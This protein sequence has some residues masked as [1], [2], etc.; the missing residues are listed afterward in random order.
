MLIGM[1]AFLA[2]LWRRKRSQCFE[3]QIRIERVEHYPFE[4][5]DLIAQWSLANFKGHTRKA[6]VDRRQSATWNETFTVPKIAIPI[7]KATFR[8]GKATMFVTLTEGK[9]VIGSV[10]IDASQFLTSRTW[11]TARH[12]LRD[13]R[14][15]SRLQVSIKSRQTK[16]SPMFQSGTPVA[17]PDRTATPPRIDST[18]QARLLE[19]SEGERKRMRQ[20]STWS[21]GDRRPAEPIWKPTTRRSSV[22]SVVQGI[23]GESMADDADHDHGQVMTACDRALINELDGSS[24][25]RFRTI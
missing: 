23:I 1:G 3:I 13:S 7:D 6:R 20:S 17:L 11:S 21:A 10:T 18:M 9:A 5:A 22:H 15:N 19:P 14:T 2:R 16:G 25:F 8:P 12:L 24:I 4:G